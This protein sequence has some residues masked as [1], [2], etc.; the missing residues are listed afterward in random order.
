MKNIIFS[1]TIISSII[2]FESCSKR[3]DTVPTP[4]QIDSVKVFG[5]DSSELVRSITSVWTD[6]LGNVQDSSIS[7]FYYDTVNRKIFSA[8]TVITASNPPN[9]TNIFSYNASYQI[10]NLKIN[11][12]LVD[13]GDAVSIDYV[14]DNEHIISTETETHKDN[15]QEVRNFQKTSLAGGYTLSS[16]DIDESFDTTISAFNFNSDGRLN[17]SSVTTLP[18][19]SPWISDSLVYDAAGNVSTVIENN[20]FNPSQVNAFSM[21]SRTT[22]GNELSVFNKIL[23]N[24]ISQLPDINGGNFDGGDQLNG[25]DNFYFYQ[26]TVYPASS[27]TVYYQSTSSYVTFNTGA[28]FD[29]KNRLVSYKMFN[30]DNSF[31]YM[32]VKLVYYK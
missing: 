24:G 6:S 11:P 1:V 30:G 7:Y 22:K 28:Q 31:Y 14:Y 17:Y 8:P 20:I 13:T 4:Q 2:S 9:Y 25:Y 26:F 27:A 29:N 19:T 21:T 5:V 3:G 10:S 18:D 23:F 12:A 32:T 15:V 16:V